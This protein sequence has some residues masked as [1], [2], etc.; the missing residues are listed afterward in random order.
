MFD[1]FRKSDEPAR[2]QKPDEARPSPGGFGRRQTPVGQTSGGGSAAMDAPPASSPP[3]GGFGRRAAPAASAEPPSSSGQDLKRLSQVGA[4]IAQHLM[5][6]YRD[7]RGV[8]VE[9]IVG[10]AAVLAGEFALRASAPR[11]PD[12]GWIAGAPADALMYEGSEKTPITLWSVVH[13]VVVALGV[14][15]SQ[16]PNPRAVALRASENIGKQYPPKLSV[17]IEHYPHEFSP[18]AAPRFRNDVMAIA[19]EAD[20]D[21]T[22]TALSLAFTMALLIKNAHAVV[23]APILAQLAAELMIAVTRM[24]PLKAPIQV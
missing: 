16:M 24:A 13:T 19:R 10:A 3:S 15:K 17:P 2:S 20:L 14:D 11:L 9:T 1:R 6:A 23:P 8:H 22:E 18:N 7:P 12:S 4:K 21:P 5:Q